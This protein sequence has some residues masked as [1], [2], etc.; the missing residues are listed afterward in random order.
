MRPDRL[1]RSRCAGPRLW[2]EQHHVEPDRRRWCWPGSAAASGVDTT[3]G[4]R[5]RP[6]DA[7]RSNPR[8]WRGARHPGR[9]VRPRWWPAGSSGLDRPNAAGGAGR[10]ADTSIAEVALAHD[11]TTSYLGALGDEPGVMIT[12]GTGVVTLAVGPDDVARVD[13]WGWIMGD[14]GSAYWIGRN[15]L[16]AAMRGYDGRRRVDPADR[17]ARGRVRRSG[18]GLP[19]VAGRSRPGGAGGVLCGEGGRGGRQR[20]GGP[21]TFWTRRPRTWPRRSSRPR[22]GWVWAATVH[23]WCVR[24]VRRSGRPG[25]LRSSFST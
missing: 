15:A 17:D 23:R 16:E 1:R 8:S 11:S 2:P 9:P 12:S 3:S 19:G 10:A 5:P 4:D 18:T 24:W 7:V 22:T 13:G 21:R 6:T 20:S 25:C 14:S